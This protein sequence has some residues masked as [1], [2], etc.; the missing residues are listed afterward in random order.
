MKC[1]YFFKEDIGCCCRECL[2]EEHGINLSSG[3]CLYFMYPAV[4]TRCKEV[5]HIVT[6]VR[7]S[8][9]IKLFL[10]FK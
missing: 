8:K 4:C 1:Y 10:G 9:K 6:G 3:D 5:K 7:L 2:N